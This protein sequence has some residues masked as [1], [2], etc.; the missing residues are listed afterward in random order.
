MKLTNRYAKTMML[1]SFILTCALAMPALSFA[2]RNEA[3]D[4]PKAWTPEQSMKVRGVGGVNVSPDGK[5][6]LYTVNEAVMT[7]EKSEYLS[8]I[9]MAN[10]DGSDVR[11]MTFGE[12]SSGSPDWSPDGKWIA[13]TSSR[14]GKNNLYLISATAGEAEMITDVKSGVGSYS[15]SPDGKSIA[16]TMSDAPS[17]DEEKN[18]KGKDDSRWIDENTKMNHLWVVPVAKDANGK[19]ESRQLTKGSFTV[20]SGLGGGGFDWSPDSKSIVFNHSK[21]PKA[22][23]WVSSDVS[24]VD[25]AGGAMKPFLTTNAAETQPLY[26]PDGKWIAVSISSDPPRW[27]FNTTIN[28][29]PSGG[30]TPKP[31]AQTFDEQPNI[32][33]WAA[34]GKRIYF[35]ETRG[36]ASSLSS[37]NVETNA[38]TEIDKGRAAYGGVNLNRSRTMFGLVMQTNNTPVEAFVTRSDAFSPV[39]ISNANTGLPKLALGKVEN[40]RWKSGDG[41]EIE[42][43]LNYPVDYRAGTKVPLLLVI[44]GGPAGVFTQGFAASPNLYPTAVF[45]A[46]GYAVLRPNPRGSSG[47]GKKFRFA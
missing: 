35:G 18:N 8:Q 4:P 30:G 19:R 31:L 39:R 23:D 16:F 32:I 7:P 17:A 24:I 2:L 33:G 34:D 20:G 21:S 10:A 42:G 22:D 41:T 11:Q 15:W 27:A 14:S 29:I 25:V 3:S 5:R 40:V 9:W 1:L 6:V 38:I 45:N 36:T 28:L 46:R 44:H 47:Y 37:I 26:S 43:I 13:F 12:K